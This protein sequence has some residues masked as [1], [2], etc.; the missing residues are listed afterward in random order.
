[1]I[2]YTLI[3][4]PS[5]ELQINFD[6]D[7]CDYSKIVE[8]ST[9]LEPPIRLQFV[10]NQNPFTVTLTPSSVDTVETLGLGGLFIN[11]VGISQDSR[12]TAGLWT[13]IREILLNHNIYIT[14]QK[15]SACTS[16]SY[17]YTSIF[18]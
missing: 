7:G 4:N 16:M 6:V 17:T 10:R 3:C 18:P 8:G 11:T 13:N 1:M 12:A 2:M 15:T 5:S 9:S 14:E